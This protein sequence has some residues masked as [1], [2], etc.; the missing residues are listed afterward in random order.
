MHGTLKENGTFVRQVDSYLRHSVYN[1][2][3]ILSDIYFLQRNKEQHEAA[4]ALRDSVLRLR[5]DGAFI[6]VPLSRV[7]TEPIGPHPA[8]D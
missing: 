8:G 7:N 1:L 6:A 3:T 5:R 4:L 2:D